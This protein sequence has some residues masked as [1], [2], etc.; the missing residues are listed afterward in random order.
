MTLHSGS[1]DN[2]PCSAKRHARAIGQLAGQ[3]SRAAQAHW[4]VDRRTL[5]CREFVPWVWAWSGGC[6]GDLSKQWSVVVARQ[7]AQGCWW[8]AN[9]VQY[10][11]TSAP[12]SCAIEGRAPATHDPR[13]L[14]AARPSELPRRHFPRSAALPTTP[15]TWTAAPAC[16]LAD[17]IKHRG[18]SPDARA[19]SAFELVLRSSWVSR[20]GD[21]PL[22]RACERLGRSS[23]RRS[24]SLP[25]AKSSRCLT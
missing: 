6:V 9:R 18:G 4:L 13:G 21:P 8:H 11:D 19:C 23:W 5:A 20:I 7:P 24:P 3:V 1:D 14:R 12:P 15:N 17:H 2:V 25:S 22:C 10:R 16:E